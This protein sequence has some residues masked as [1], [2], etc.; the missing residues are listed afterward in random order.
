MV[1]PTPLDSTWLREHPL[2]EPDNDADKNER[3]RVLVIGGA[4]TVPGGLL[5]TAEGALRAGAGKVRLATIEGAAIP[6][7]VAMPECAVFALP[8]RAD[9]EIADDCAEALEPLFERCD[10]IVAG[11]AMS[12]GRAAAR[13][14]DLLIGAS[15]C[16][17]PLVLDAAA[18]MR[19]PERAKALADCGRPAILTPHIG[20][21]AAMLECDAGE[22]EADRTAAVREAAARY[23]AITLLKGAT[24]L[25]ATPEGET[26]AYAGGGVGL[27]TGGSGDVMTGIVGGLVARGAEPLVAVLWAVWLH[28]EAG[29]RCAEQTGPLGFLARELPA[30]VP[31]LMR[32]V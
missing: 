14:A 28:G 16:E 4:R 32:G 7:G 30:H 19:L 26:F 1:E 22:I 9:G 3:G 21:M 2:P 6:L 18:L 17:A 5:L 12:C 8:E 29:R 20:E 23:H 31:G 11:P 13:I 25:V 24:T 15:G 27:A 10:T